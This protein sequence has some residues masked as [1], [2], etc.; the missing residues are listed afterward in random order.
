M[1]N[2]K[3]SDALQILLENARDYD[4]FEVTIFLRGEP[5]RAALDRA[6]A[7]GTESAK[8]AVEDIKSQAAT[9]QQGVLDF[10]SEASRSALDVDESVS[11]PKAAAID[12][13]WVT[14]S[15]S[16]QVTPEVLRALL[17]RDDVLS[18]D[19]ART[20]DVSELLDQPTAT[21]TKT[22][23]KK[24]RGDGA[25]KPARKA[26]AAAAAVSQGT[27]TWSVQRI[28]APLLWQLGI[29][30]EGVLAAVI[31]TGVNYHHPDL[32]SQMWDGGD[33][34]PNH[35]FDFESNDTN[36]IDE[37]GHGTSCA[38]IVAGNGAKGQGTGVAP[39]A[40][41]MALRVGGRES[42]YWK[43]FE[44]AI[45]RGVQVISMSMSWKYPNNPNYTGW[46][47]A[48]E[49]LAAA[50]ILH[51]NSIG[52]Q[53]DRLQEYPIPYNI[54]TPGN[55][56]PPR[57]HLLQTP[58]GGTSSVIGC[59][60]T[61][62]ADRLAVYSGRGPAEWN[63]APFTDYPYQGGARPGLIKPDVCAP[64]PGT[65]SCNWQYTPDSAGATPYSSFGGTSAATPHVGGCLVLLAHACT[66]AGKPIVA[67][68][69]QEALENTAVRMPGQTRD[70]E[71]NFG[72]GRVDVYAAYKY[73]H[74]KGWW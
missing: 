25:A 69:V 20:V 68:R 64:G 37:A 54:A 59:G 29:T 47:R 42:N 58:V 19:L 67:A 34:Y 57:L 9:E 66:K 31:D 13:S 22:K 1:T 71:Y 62:N 6:E 39:K 51:A 24:A 35:G 53:G 10:L 48:S 63:N 72:A 4:T 14:N 11:V 12:T 70:K 50:G 43:A 27:P 45:D 61:D 65:T 5:A 40:T 73:G 44:F 2:S 30:G 32:K 7:A 56:P 49:A 46:R 8:S 18:V 28:N 23:K 52:N 15:I 17:E 26:R 36:P 41:V 55:C 16:A 38:G 60:A 33:T 3:A 74:D 21:P